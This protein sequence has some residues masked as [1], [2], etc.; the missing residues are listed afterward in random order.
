M[1]PGGHIAGKDAGT[2]PDGHGC[3][4][5][6][7]NA[8]AHGCSLCGYSFEDSAVPPTGHTYHARIERAAD[9]LNEGLA[10]YTCAVCSDSFTQVIPATG[11]T[12]VRDP[13]V[14]ATCKTAGKTAG[15]HCSVCGAVI[16]AQSTVPVRD[17]RYENGVCVWCGT[18]EPHN[19]TAQS[20]IPVVVENQQPEPELPPWNGQAIEL[21]IIF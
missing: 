4:H 3:A 10:R 7:R 9:C 1:Q 6:E 20:E 17:H 18:P 5:P 21:P 15:S 11:H 8:H 12:E 13:A 16:Q 2:I 19:T 14:E